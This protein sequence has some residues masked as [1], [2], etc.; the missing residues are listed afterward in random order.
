MWLT[1]L[2]SGFIFSLSLCFICF[3][4]WFFD[5]SGGK[6]ASISMIIFFLRLQSSSLSVDLDLFLSNLASIIISTCIRSNSNRSTRGRGNW[7]THSILRTR[8]RASEIQIITRRIP[9]NTREYL[10]LMDPSHH[11]TIVITLGLLSICSVLCSDDSA[12]LPLPNIHYNFVE[13]R[14]WTWLV[15][16]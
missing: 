16:Y 15:N 7:Q 3:F 8:A 4:L 9:E 10:D 1:Y 14:I 11:P 6:E 13:S 12:S 5:K 2:H